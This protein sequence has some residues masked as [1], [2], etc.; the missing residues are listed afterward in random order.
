MSVIELLQIIKH[1]WEIFKDNVSMKK[2]YILYHV[3][4]LELI[5]QKYCLRLLKDVEIQSEFLQKLVFISVRILKWGKLTKNW[6]WYFF[7]KWKYL[8]DD[9]D[10]DY[11]CH[12][13]HY[14]YNYHKH[15][16]LIICGARLNCN[17]FIQM[18][19]KNVSGKYK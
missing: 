13:Y 7:S 9:D 19:E 8:K 1:M 4:C 14:H 2:T 17:I 6:L 16:L 15:Y 12:H 18:W 5:G 10:D 3:N 11:H